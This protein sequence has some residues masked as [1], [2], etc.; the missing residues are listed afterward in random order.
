MASIR[1]LLDAYKANQIKVPIATRVQ[2]GLA[3]E[4]DPVSNQWITVGDVTTLQAARIAYERGKPRF[5]LDQDAPV[6]MGVAPELEAYDD[7]K[8]LPF[9]S[10]NVESAYFVSYA[11]GLPAGATRGDLYIKFQARKG[12]KPDGE[13]R[14]DARA[15][16]Y[17][18]VPGFLWE[19]LMHANS[20]GGTVHDL[21]RK[22]GIPGDQIL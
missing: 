17:Q 3:R 6:A 21:I 7:D 4:W 22:G 15:Y 5:P 19:A 1:E 2:G 20:P 9:Y 12:D 13:P 11:P 14:G 18:N 8:G 16:V 10:S